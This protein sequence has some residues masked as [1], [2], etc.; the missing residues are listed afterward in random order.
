MAKFAQIPN[1]QQLGDIKDFEII[2][3]EGEINLAGN[4]LT[5]GRNYLLKH[6]RADM[7][8]I[9]ANAAYMMKV[10]SNSIVVAQY[11]AEKF[12]AEVSEIVVGAFVV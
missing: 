8:Q 1:R 7:L 3:G 6:L 9:I 5:V 12:E 2:Y 4:K 10:S 11:V